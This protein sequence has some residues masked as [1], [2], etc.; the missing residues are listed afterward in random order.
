MNVGM[1]SNRQFQAHATRHRKFLLLILPN[2]IYKPYSDY[3][4]P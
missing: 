4:R 1:M 2:S 3:A